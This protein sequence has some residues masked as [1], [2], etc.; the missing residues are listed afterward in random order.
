MTSTEWEMNA[1]APEAPDAPQ[2]P[3]RRRG[4]PFLAL[5]GLLL[6][7][8]AGAVLLTQIPAYGAARAALPRS[9]VLGG[10][11]VGG[12]SAEDAKAR[13]I[14]AY[15]APIV[16]TFEGQQYTLNPSEVGFQ[17]D[18]DGMLAQAAAQKQ[19]DSDYWPG[20][21]DF[22]W[23]RPGPAVVVPLQ[24]THS[25]DAL[26][27]VVANLATKGN[28]PPGPAQPV[29]ETL[30]FA[31]GQPGETLDEEAAMEDIRAALYRTDNRSV[32]VQSV[33]HDAPRPG[34]DTLKTLIER[35]LVASQFRGV[36]SVYIIDEQTGEELYANIDTRSG[37]PNPITCDIAYAGLSTMKLTILTEYYRYLAW[38]PFNYE[39]DV[40]DKTIVQ[41]SNLLAN[42]ML[43]DLG[44]GDPYAGARAVTDS[45]HH[46]GMENTFI[47][48]PYDDEIE[49][50]YYS[51]PARE[52]ARSGA[53]LN[54]LPDPYMQTTAPDLALLLDMM[55][56]CSERG[57]GLGAAY[58]EDIT[59]TECQAMVDVLGRNVEGKLIRAGVPE[60]TTVAHKH[61]YGVTD[62]MSD[63]GI[64]YSPGGNYVIV[65]FLWAETTWLDAFETFPIMRDISAATFNYFNPDLI[66]EPRMSIE[67]ML[68]LEE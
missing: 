21:W 9:L 10:V 2:Q 60:G 47:I 23:N 3:A 6:M 59:Q 4:F 38:E 56:Q 66:Y 63:A 41:S 62:T 29:L 22:L 65:M 35:Y 49:P 14:E 31:A 36:V 58:P 16:V 48:A 30:S 34:M 11:N 57:G 44:Y 37:A 7:L 68:S 42:S 28:H 17:I 53:C 51:T 26:R 33:P 25:E 15:A 39:L 1:P 46:L 67:E 45:M 27:G 5:A 20:F 13:L 24:A 55:Y 43:S 50:Q 12:L 52:A 19:A 32:E 61:G 64:V 40:I 54:T 8:A 18:A